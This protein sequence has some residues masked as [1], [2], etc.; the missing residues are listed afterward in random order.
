MTTTTLARGSEYGPIDTT[1]VGEW[2]GLEDH[3]ARTATRLLDAWLDLVAPSLTWQPTTSTILG[4]VGYRGPVPEPDH[5]TDARHRIVETLSDKCLP[6]TDDDVRAWLDATT[7][8]TLDLHDHLPHLTTEC[9]YCG[10]DVPTDDGPVPPHTDDDAWDH[11]AT[12]HDPDCEWIRTRAHTLQDWS[13]HIPTRV[14]ADRGP[15]TIHQ[16][17]C[18]WLCDDPAGPRLT[19]AEA[20]LTLGLKA[21]QEV[22]THLARARETADDYGHLYWYTT[23]TD[24]PTRTKHA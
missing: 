21:R 8:D 23:R 15:L 1:T 3:V 5:W 17:L 16:A 19:H 4:S 22:G 24:D 9:A 6:G 14:L 18:A 10:R 20:A 13:R 7:L 2:A 12:H 11:L